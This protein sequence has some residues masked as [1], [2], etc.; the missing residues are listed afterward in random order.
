MGHGKGKITGRD[1]AKMGGMSEMIA[2]LVKRI[3]EGNNEV[4]DASVAQIKHIA[5]QNHGEHTEA[6]YKAGAVKP[7]VQLLV[8]GSADAQYNACSALASLAEGKPDVQSAIADGGGVPTIVK[9][10]RMGGSAVQE[11]VR[12]P[13]L[14]QLFGGGSRTSHE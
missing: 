3:T 10:L 2:S 4:K 9:L 1:I 11:Q 14:P 7:L 12:N 6:L 5:S 13:S 8:N